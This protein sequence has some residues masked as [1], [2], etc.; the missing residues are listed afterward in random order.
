MNK[1]FQFLMKSSVPIFFCCYSWFGLISK[2][3]STKIRSWRITL[4]FLLK[5]VWYY[6]L[7]LGNCSIF[8]SVLYMMWVQGQ[9]HSSPPLNMVVQASQHHFWKGCFLP[10]WTILAPL[11][12]ISW[13]CIYGFISGFNCILLVHISVLMP[14]PHCFDYYSLVVGFEIGKCKFSKLWIE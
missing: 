4:I 2:S 5:V 8:S 3:S 9:L 10:H 7:Y 11:L 13:L 12:I 14:V 1:S 6:L